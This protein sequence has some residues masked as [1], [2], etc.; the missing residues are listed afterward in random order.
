MWHETYHP[1]EGD[2]L[3]D[4]LTGLSEEEIKIA[5]DQI[6]A[7]IAGKIRNYRVSFDEDTWFDV[8]NGIVRGSSNLGR[9]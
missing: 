9:K 2:N 6:N 1:L 4:I 8:E 7:A 3:K 5:T